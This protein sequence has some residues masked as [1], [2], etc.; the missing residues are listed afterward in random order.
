MGYQ[1]TGTDTAGARTGRDSSPSRKEARER[2]LLPAGGVWGPW[3]VGMGTA[4]TETKST[5][6]FSQTPAEFLGSC[7][8]KQTLY[9]LILRLIC[10]FC[11]WKAKSQQTPAKKRIAMKKDHNIAEVA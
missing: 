9:Y 3:E 10:L 6:T 8:R 7:L 11:A 1:P 4:R 2:L 5:S